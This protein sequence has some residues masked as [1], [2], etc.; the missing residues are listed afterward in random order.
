M[1]NDDTLALSQ[2]LVSKAPVPESVIP[3]EDGKNVDSEETHSDKKHDGG[4]EVNAGV[5]NVSSAH[6]AADAT[7]AGVHTDASK[8]MLAVSASQS[9]QS[10]LVPASTLFLPPRMQGAVTEEQHVTKRSGGAADG[11]GKSAPSSSI[12]DLGKIP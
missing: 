7:S 8:D 11:D 3:P 2:P 10:V 6:L 1:D 4:S 9:T 12:Q 5:D